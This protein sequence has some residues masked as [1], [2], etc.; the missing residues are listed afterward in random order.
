MSDAVALLRQLYEARDQWVAAGLDVAEFDA[1]AL[2]V[3]ALLTALAERKSR[4]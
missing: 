1:N 4:Q 2:R 3:L